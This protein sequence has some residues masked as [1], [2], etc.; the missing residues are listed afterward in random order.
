MWQDMN[1]VGQPNLVNSI[2]F[3]LKEEMFIYKLNAQGIWDRQRVKCNRK[4][5]DI[6]FKIEADVKPDTDN[7]TGKP[8]PVTEP[9]TEPPP[10]NPVPPPTPPVPEQITTRSSI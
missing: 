3:S 6:D 9:T 8:K 4:A 2:N 10:A 7:V 1:T 5:G